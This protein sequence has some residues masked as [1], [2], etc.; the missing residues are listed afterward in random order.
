MI[1]ELIAII[2][3]FIGVIWTLKL[4]INNKP[5]K[6]FKPTDKN[7]SFYI[8]RTGKYAIS[9]VKGKF[10][11]ILNGFRILISKNFK[12]NSNLDINELKLRNKTYNKWHIGVEFLIFDI[13]E[14]GS[15]QL[16][17]ENDN[18]LV[19]KT[20]RFATNF[21]ILDEVEKDEI[22]FAI[23]KY[24]PFYQRMIATLFMIIGLIVILWVN[25]K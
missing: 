21:R 11:T 7:V 3:I 6:F 1:I 4:T 5:I 16:N 23:E 2:S 14:T 8:N 10:V 18:K 15:Y 20:P 22:E 13:K 24:Y 19:V 25:I 9:T 17:I 12:S